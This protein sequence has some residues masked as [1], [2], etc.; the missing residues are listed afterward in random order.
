VVVTQTA[1]T[2]RAFAEQGGYDVDAG[3]DFLGAGAGSVVAGLVGAFPVDASPPRTGAVARAGGRTQAGALG[4]AAAV[5]L[6]IPFAN[7][8]RDV[9]LA[10]LAAIL[11]G[12]AVHIFDV[13]GLMA[14]AR[15]SWLEF[16][17]AAVTLVAVV[18]I[19]VEQGIAVAVLLA[20][21]DRIRISARP[22]LHV[23]GRIP[24]TTSWAR[25]AFEP[26]AA[27][28]E[29]VLVVMFATP[30]WYANAVRFREEVAEAMARA[31]AVR[32]LVLDT[33]GESDIDFTGSRAMTRVVEACERDGVALGIARAGAHL[34]ESL[35]RSGLS[36]RIGE[37]HFYDTV[38][39]A[40]RALAPDADPPGPA[41][42]P[43]G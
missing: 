12:I 2:T 8:L 41:E 31:G 6:L 10:A 42:S 30:V 39:E 26:R 15:F 14:I 7:I 16:G 37:E 25:P 35:R 4:A 9:P 34:H 22:Q 33:I 43:A 20:I 28:V 11:I 3:R 24:G 13:R 21:L 38:D 17:L 5:L 27:P 29:G 1:A 18:L 40:V 36:V 23:L 32:V 19:G